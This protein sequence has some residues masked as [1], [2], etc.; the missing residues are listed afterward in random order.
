[1]TQDAMTHREKRKQDYRKQIENPSD[2]LRASWKLEDKRDEMIRE[3]AERKAQGAP[4]PY[5]LEIV[6]E[7]K[8]K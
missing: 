8:I 3:Q 7:V 4:A 6:S 2:A 5:V 1:M